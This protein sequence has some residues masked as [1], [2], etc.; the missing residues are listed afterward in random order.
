MDAYETRV[1]ENEKKKLL[2]PIPLDEEVKL[3]VSYQKRQWGASWWEQYSILFQRG[4]KERRHEYFS[5]LR[6]SQVLSTAFILGLLWWQSDS[7]SPKGLHEQVNQFLIK[8]YKLSDLNVTKKPPLFS[9]RKTS[10]SHYA[11]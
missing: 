8:F 1:A 2:I 6:V 10:W 3:K 11:Y 9:T 4:I 5:W 7:N